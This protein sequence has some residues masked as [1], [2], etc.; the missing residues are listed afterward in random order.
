M[1]ICA[2]VPASFLFLIAPLVLVSML[3]LLLH[4]DPPAR[5]RGRHLVTSS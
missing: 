5:P 4:P 1:M 2:A 3:T